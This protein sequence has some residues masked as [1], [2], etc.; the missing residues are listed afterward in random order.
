MVSSVDE[1]WAQGPA[2]DIVILENLYEQ[3]GISKSGTFGK[4]EIVEQCLV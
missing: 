3:L 4:L 2:F 1:I